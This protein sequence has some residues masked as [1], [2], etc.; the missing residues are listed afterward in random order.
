MNES[1]KV[2]RQFGDARFRVLRTS[3]EIA[4]DTHRIAREL[5]ELVE[6]QTPVFI[7]LLKGSMV[8]L[9][10][11]IRAYDG[12]QEIDFLSVTRYDPKQ[13]DKH[14][15]RVLH[16]LATSIDGRVVIVVEGIRS[17]GTKVEYVER[18]L[19]IH[20]AARIY[21]CAMV[22]QKGSVLGP[23]PLETWGFEIEDDDEYVVG[24]GLDLDESYRNLPFI[25]I[26]EESAATGRAG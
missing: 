25:G 24:Y 6:D 18:F 12:P 2:I 10:D 20:G 15:V 19:C 3:A 21:Y 11:L 14:S 22:R 17:G 13:K 26:K 7:G 23:V 8:F 16:D 5:K 9:A 4:E 1:G